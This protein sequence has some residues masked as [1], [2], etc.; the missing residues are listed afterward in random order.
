MLLGA[1]VQ[2]YSGDY[3]IISSGIINIKS[4][5]FKIRVKNLIF[6]FYFMK[7]DSG[8]THYNGNS[9]SDTEIRLNVFNMNNGLLEGFYTPMEIG[10]LGGRRF[11]IN[12]AAWTLDVEENIRSVVYNLLLAREN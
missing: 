3:E 10:T 4:D 2:V 6:D 8:K 1:D 7:D 5:N 11:F 12:F 9:I